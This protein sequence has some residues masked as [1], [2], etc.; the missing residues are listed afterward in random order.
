MKLF[1][2]V[3]FLLFATSVRA[4][5]RSRSGGGVEASADS[6]LPWEI[7]VGKQ[8]SLSTRSLS[9]RYTKLG[10]VTTSKAAIADGPPNPV[11]PTL[12]N[13]PISGPYAAATTQAIQSGWVAGATADVAFVG[14]GG[15]G[16]PQSTSNNFDAF[17]YNLIAL[18]AFSLDSFD[19]QL[20][21]APA[22]PTKICFAGGGAT[23]APHNVAA[24][25]VKTAFVINKW[26]WDSTAVYWR[27]TFDIV[28]N[29]FTAPNKTVDDSSTD[30]VLVTYTDSDGYKFD[31][32]VNKKFNKGD[33]TL[34]SGQSSYSQSGNTVTVNIDIPKADLVSGGTAWWL[35]DPEVSVTGGPAPNGTSTGPGGGASSARAGIAVVLTTVLAAILASAF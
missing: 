23:C 15:V 25:T 21:P 27:I 13:I 22:A 10:E 2:A 17:A 12:H 29:G 35:Y 4:T 18:R 26:V 9:V 5:V 32:K 8:G 14:F 19:F 34:S 16:L 31:L 33:N 30:Y 11:L 6:D 28:P 1:V 24:G 20:N 7:K 3:A